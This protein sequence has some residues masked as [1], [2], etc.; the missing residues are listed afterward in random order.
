MR[1]GY[2]GIGLTLAIV[3][4]VMIMYQVLFGLG[5]V[6]FYGLNEENWNPQGVLLLNAVAQIIA[7]G[8]GAWLVAASAKQDISTVFRLNPVHSRA[9]ASMYLLILPLIL[10]AQ[11]LGAGLA[12]LWMHLLQL[13][14]SLFETLRKV[15]DLL[16]SSMKKLV[17][18]DNPTQLVIGLISIAVVPAMCEELFF[19]GFTL[20]NIERSGKNGLRTGTGIVLSALIFGLAHVSPINLPALVVLGLVFG[21]L[22][23]KTNDIRITMTAHFIN[24]GI[25]VVAL[26]FLAGEQ[27]ITETLLS[28]EALP[29]ADSLLLT[30]VCTVLLV[31][32]LAYIGKLAMQ[33]S[34]TFP[35]ESHTDT[36]E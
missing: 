25:V 18:A 21:W 15:Q 3:L 23:V 32:I 19:R 14:P 10:V 4:G 1:N 24:N 22:L 16:D 2:F 27:D 20:A 30:G 17:I 13:S 29:L 26:Y 5:T 11:A 12:S 35:N 6:V 8:G 7:L 36:H 34:P 9:S 33:N 28:S 31:A